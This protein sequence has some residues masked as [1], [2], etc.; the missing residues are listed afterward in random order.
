MIEIERQC[1][2]FDEFSKIL[3]NS[4]WVL[5]NTLV[6]TPVNTVVDA[7]MGA[8]VNTLLNTPVHT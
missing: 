1:I 4:V 6:R 7:L 8:L 3:S 2:G 5:C